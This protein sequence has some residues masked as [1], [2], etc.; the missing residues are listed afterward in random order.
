MKTIG[1]VFA[2]CEQQQGE[3]EAGFWVSRQLVVES[4]DENGK[5]RHAAFSFFGDR[6]VKK[7]DA[8]KKGDMVEVTFSISARE[9]QG[10]W[11]NDLWG[12]SVSQYTRTAE[13]VPAA[14]VEARQN[15]NG[16]P[17]FKP[18]QTTQPPY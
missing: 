8:L 9:W 18:E 16:D 10:K 11:Y 6:R 14:S 7:L 12:Q 15:A 1:K 17:D 3:N 13:I 4:V 2:I 5:A